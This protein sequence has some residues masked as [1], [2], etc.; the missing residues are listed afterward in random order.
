MEVR[1]GEYDISE[2]RFLTKES[3]GRISYGVGVLNEAGFE[4]STF[5]FVPSQSNIVFA[6]TLHWEPS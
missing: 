5:N 4:S 3:N 1:G 6:S 2:G